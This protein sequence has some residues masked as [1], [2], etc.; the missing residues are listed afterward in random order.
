MQDVT[1]NIAKQIKRNRERIG[2]NK[3]ELGKA[4]GVA[5]STVSGW[6]NG[7][8]APSADTLV[9][10][11][12]LF[13]ITLDEIYGIEQSAPSSENAFDAWLITA[14]HSASEKDQEAVRVILSECSNEE[15]ADDK[16][17]VC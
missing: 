5:P 15:Y 16:S 1:A 12:D 6:E 3:K 11:C 2:L 13:E 17:E 9:K 14:Y 7:E 10:L 4:V 8:Y